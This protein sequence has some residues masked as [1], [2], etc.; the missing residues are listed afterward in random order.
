MTSILS[1]TINLRI[2][3]H[4]MYDD[5][6]S[7]NQVQALPSSSRREQASKYGR[8]SI[9]CVHYCLSLRHLR[10]GV[11]ADL[12]VRYNIFYFNLT[13][14]ETRYKYKPALINGS[15]FSCMLLIYAK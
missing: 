8:I 4:I 1:L 2:K 7:S 15:H 12:L 6:I 10:A 9:K 5:C 3:I 13:V 14:T 11:Q